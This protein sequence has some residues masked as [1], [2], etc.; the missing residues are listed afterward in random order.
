MSDFGLVSESAVEIGQGLFMNTLK[1]LTARALGLN[2]EI[3]YREIFRFGSQDGTIVLERNLQGSQV[4]IAKA[5][6]AEWM[7]YNSNK[8]GYWVVTG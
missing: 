1:R 5:L 3:K 6:G 7:T 2:D 4:E 8:N